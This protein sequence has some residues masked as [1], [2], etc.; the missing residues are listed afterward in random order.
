M[1]KWF[2]LVFLQSFYFLSNILTNIHLLRGLHHYVAIVVSYQ[3]LFLR[4]MEATFDVKL[5][6]QLLFHNMYT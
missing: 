5:S 2:V 4:S 1:F 6:V 3:T